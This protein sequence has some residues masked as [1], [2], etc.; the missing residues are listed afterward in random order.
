MAP[1]TVS[2]RCFSRLLSLHGLYVAPPTPPSLSTPPSPFRSSQNVE[3]ASINSLLQ[4]YKHRAE[5]LDAQSAKLDSY[6]NDNRTGS[7]QNG[8]DGGATGTHEQLSDELTSLRAGISGYLKEVNAAYRRCFADKECTQRI[9]A[10][11]GLIGLEKAGKLTFLSGW[12]TNG[13]S[14]QP[15]FEFNATS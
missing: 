10:K 7:R 8:H 1:D 15:C 14:S 12:A 5:E 4:R 11:I 2:S 9:E 6:V 3:S 13:A